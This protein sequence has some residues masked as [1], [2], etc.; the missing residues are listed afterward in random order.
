MASSDGFAALSIR[1]QGSAVIM[2]GELAGNPICLVIRDA[3]RK[4]GRPSA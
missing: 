1:S 4:S 2:A 3:S